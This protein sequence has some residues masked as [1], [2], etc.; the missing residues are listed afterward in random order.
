[1]VSQAEKYNRL[2]VSAILEYVDEDSVDKLAIKYNSLTVSLSS[3]PTLIPS[4]IDIEV[5]NTSSDVITE[6][7]TLRIGGNRTDSETLLFNGSDV[8]TVTFNY[9]FP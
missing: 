7:V 4:T 2:N 6:T 1:M 5:E 3:S 9:S 8:K